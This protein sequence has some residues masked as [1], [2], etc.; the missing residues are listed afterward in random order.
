MQLKFFYAFV[1]SFVISIGLTAAIFLIA[2]KYNLASQPSADRWHKTPTPNMGGIAIFIAWFV[3]MFFLAMPSI[4]RMGLMVSGALAFLLGLIDDIWPMS[5]IY[6]LGAQIVVALSVIFFGIHVEIITNVY[7]AV[8][9]TV[10]WI[11]AIM[12]AIN[13]IDNMDG[14]CAGTSIIIALNLFGLGLVFPSYA[15]SSICMLLAGSLAGF[16]VWNFPPAKIFMGDSG[17]MFIGFELASLSLVGSWRD[18]SHLS[19]MILIPLLL[20]TLPL[21]DVILVSIIRRLNGRAISQGGRDHTSHRLVLMGLSE[22][23]TL[24][25]IWTVSFVSGLLMYS[26]TLGSLFAKIIVGSVL[27]VFLI[28]AGLFL[29]RLDTYVIEKDIKSENK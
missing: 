14:A 2:N 7:L 28:G 21:F 20:F 5:A 27:V 4:Q 1:L 16:L 29:G 15:I 24:L 25:V 26:V 3:P 19:I 8:V 10:L 9:V 23:Q 12:N 22:R 6:K 17:S 13:L 11:V 18:A